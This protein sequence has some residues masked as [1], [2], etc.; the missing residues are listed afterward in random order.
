[1]VGADIEKF[2]L[3]LLAHLES[4]PAALELVAEGPHELAFRVEDED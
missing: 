1:M 3:A 4:V 2:L